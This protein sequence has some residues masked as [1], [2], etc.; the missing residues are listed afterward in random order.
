MKLEVKEKKLADRQMRIKQIIIGGFSN[1]T[2]G[3]NPTAR[4]IRNTAMQRQATLSCRILQVHA[5]ILKH[6]AGGIV[7]TGATV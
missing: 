5:E 6:S 2:N 1:V 3:K 4:N 7:P